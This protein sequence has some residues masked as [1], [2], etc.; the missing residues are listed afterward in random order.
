MRVTRVGEPT[1]RRAVER[2]NPDLRRTPAAR[3]ARARKEALIVRFVAHVVDVTPVEARGIERLRDGAERWP[4]HRLHLR[5][6]IVTTTRAV[7][8]SDC[9]RVAPDGEARVGW[10]RGAAW[11]A[12]HLKGFSTRLVHAQHPRVAAPART[13]RGEDKVLPVRRPPRIAA[14]RAG[15]CKSHGRRAIGG[16]DPDF[17]VILVVAL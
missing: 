11:I 3:L 12:L 14:L 9:V 2:L 17:A 10:H 15:R 16:H 6:R 8:R 13:V 4:R 1:L 7:V 5:E